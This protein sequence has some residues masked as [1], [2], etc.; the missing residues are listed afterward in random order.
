MSGKT[1]GIILFIVAAAGV[2]FWYWK[3]HK[4]AGFPL[5]KIPPM[6][7]G[8][9]LQQAAAKKSGKKGWRSRLGGMAKG[10][11]KGVAANSGIPG[12]AQALYVAGV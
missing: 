11:I 9:A 2:G 12:A 3:K 10:A 6:A 1:I 7:P 8:G 4:R 5:G